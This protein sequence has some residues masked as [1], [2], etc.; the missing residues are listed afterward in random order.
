MGYPSALCL[1][2]AVC[3]L[4][5]Q[6]VPFE[7][8]PSAEYQKVS[9]LD[10]V[11]NGTV[12]ESGSTNVTY[13]YSLPEPCRDDSFEVDGVTFYKYPAGG[14]DVDPGFWEERGIILQNTAK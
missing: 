4:G 7:E 5:I 11:R 10:L 6:A 14:V 2:L 8:A 1:V 9:I 13:K 3:T 12:K